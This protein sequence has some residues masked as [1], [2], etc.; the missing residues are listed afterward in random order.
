LI[1]AYTKPEVTELGGLGQ[2]DEEE[3]PV[4]EPVTAPGVRFKVLVCPL[5]PLVMKYR[6]PPLLN[7]P[8]KYRA[9][10][11][12]SATTTTVGTT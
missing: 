5:R 10:P 6:D 12:M 3:A 11:A 9:P 1:L 8:E 7:A 4:D 2:P